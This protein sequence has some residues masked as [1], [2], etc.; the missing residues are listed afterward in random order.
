MA[1]TNLAETLD[2]ALKRPGRF[3]RQVRLHC[4]TSNGADTPVAQDMFGG[5]PSIDVVGLLVSS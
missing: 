2:P 3:D 5:L 4:I 1:A